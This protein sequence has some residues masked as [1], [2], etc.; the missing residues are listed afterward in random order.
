[1]NL[2]DTKKI[3]MIQALE[4]AD[5]QELLISSDDKVQASSQAGAPLP[6]TLGQSG[7]DS[8]FCKTG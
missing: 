7:E 3:L 1:M 5:D 4:E 2:E 6:E 8:F